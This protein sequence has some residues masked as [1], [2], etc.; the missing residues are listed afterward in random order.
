MFIMTRA[1]IKNL[2]NVTESEERNSSQAEE[3]LPTSSGLGTKTM[4]TEVHSWWKDQMTRHFKCA[5]SS[6]VSSDSDD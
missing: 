2:P 4:V 5:S 1:G 3:P 6:A